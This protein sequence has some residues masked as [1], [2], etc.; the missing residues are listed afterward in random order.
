MTE[1]HDEHADYVSGEEEYE[2][3][4]ADLLDAAEGVDEFSEEEGLVDDEI[5]EDGKLPG[6]RFA[7][8]PPCLLVLRPPG[9][10]CPTCIVRK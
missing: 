1:Y 3:E 10:L 5:D 6:C 7:A 4:D 2:E 8:A 9:R